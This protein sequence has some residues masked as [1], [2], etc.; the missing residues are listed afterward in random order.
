MNVKNLKKSLIVVLAAGLIAG[1]L[2][3]CNNG[4][5]SSSSAES[6]ISATP[7]NATVDVAEIADKLNSEIKFDEKLGEIDGG[8]ITSVIGVSEDKYA[9]AK[10]LISSSGAT[11]EEIDCFEAKDEDA[12]KEIKT[13]LESRIEAQKKTFKDYNADQAPKLDNAVLSVKGKYVYLCI[14]GD[15]DKAKE[16][17]G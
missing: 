12:A 17:I 15:S 2:T 13:A 11:P 1:C 4:E 5:T 8:K 7:A 3:G 6:A 10:C 16:I 9:N 14:S